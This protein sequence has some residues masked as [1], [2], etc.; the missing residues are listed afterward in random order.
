MFTFTQTVA[1]HHFINMEQR[2][3]T[4]M[5]RTP[6]PDSPF[7]LG[8]PSQCWSHFHSRLICHIHIKVHKTSTELEDL[9]CALWTSGGWLDFLLG[10][11][12]QP[13]PGRRHYHSSRVASSPSLTQ[14][15]DLG[16]GQWCPLLLSRGA[17][18]GSG[19]CTSSGFLHRVSPLSSASA[20]GIQ[21]GRL[22]L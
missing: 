9:I 1:T 21:R 7:S 12:K 22:T 6:S 17:G 13:P 10:G 2:G 3:T 14:S 5:H 20:L 11:S 19:V 4:P 15:R 18:S 8:F 16:G